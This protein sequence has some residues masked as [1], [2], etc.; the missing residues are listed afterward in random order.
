M[1][2]SHSATL[3]LTLYLVV[4]MSFLVGARSP[5]VGA[6]PGQR[7][8]VIFEETFENVSFPSAQWL[9]DDHPSHQREDGR[10]GDRGELFRA[11]GV[12]APKA[13]RISARF[14][15]NDWLTVE[16]YSHSDATR[17]G[18]LFARVPDPAADMPANHVLRVASPAHTDGTVIRPTNPLPSEYRVCVKV[19]HADFGDGLK[20]PGRLNGYQGTET[21]PW[22]MGKPIKDNGFYWLAIIDDVP[23]PRNNVWAHHHRKLTIDSDNNPDSWSEIWDG[24]KFIRSGVRPVFVLGVDREGRD[25]EDT[26]KPYISF[27]GGKF[28]PPNTVRAV[29]AYK[30]RTWYTACI[31]RLQTNYWMSVSG[32]FRFGGN[33]TYIGAIPIARVYHS[34]I[35]PGGWPEYFM[36][37]DPH[38]NY[39]RGA[40]YYDDLR[41]EIPAD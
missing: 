8:K 7:W 34:E 13:Y 10:F 36:F 26:G 18:G 14:G 39:Y 9:P 11:R 30:D 19:G 1:R 16:S 20:G 25:Y 38:T 29:D 37:G 17:P 27:A 32:D 4:V 33:T 31:A 12:N 41:L 15:A 3:H 2:S 6:Q 5:Q 28:Q 23:R 24:R 40:V 21:D 22:R 35:G